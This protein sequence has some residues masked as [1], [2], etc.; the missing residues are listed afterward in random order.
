MHN[1]SRNS[2]DLHR[3]GNSR[4]FCCSGSPVPKIVARR[5]IKLLSKFRAA[6]LNKSLITNRSDDGFFL[7]PHTFSFFH[8]CW[9]VRC[10]QTGSRLVF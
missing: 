4:N 8:I 5:L 1:G 3:L 6:S 9:D 2:I 7:L 10:V